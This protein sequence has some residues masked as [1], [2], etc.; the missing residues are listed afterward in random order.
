M[1]LSPKQSAFVSAIL[2]G[3]TPLEAVVD[4]GYSDAPRVSAF[5]LTHNKKIIAALQIN[6]AS[7]AMTTQPPASFWQPAKIP[8]VEKFSRDECLSALAFIARDTDQTLQARLLAMKMLADMER[9][10][11]STP[12]SASI[13][14]NLGNVEGKL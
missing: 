4:A 2:N 6:K 14:V 13:T 1:R 8:L 11:E 3:R 12:V 7:T 10:G 5:K 9:W